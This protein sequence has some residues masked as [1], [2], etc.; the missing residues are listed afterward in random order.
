MSTVPDLLD[1][2]QRL[3]AIPSPSQAS[4]AAIA[5]YL[6]ELLI[7][8]DFALE[9]L[10]YEEQGERK[11]SLVARKAPPPHSQPQTSDA[12]STWC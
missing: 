9:E 3:I 10:D 12:R 1:L 5:A 7:D 6:A 2:T 4:N 11:V 8:L